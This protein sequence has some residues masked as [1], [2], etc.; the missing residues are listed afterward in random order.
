MPHDA[1]AATATVTV[2]G[3]AAR[4]VEPDEA[5]LAVTLEALSSDPGSALADV[6]RRSEALGALLDELAIAAADR[7]TTRVSVQEEVDHVHGER[8]SRGHRAVATVSVRVTDSKPLGALLTRTTS[9]LGARVDGPHWR[10]AEDNPAH[11]QAARDAAAASRRRAQAYAEGVGA[12]LGRVIALSEP[13][14]SVVRPTRLSNAAI[15]MA[16]PAG[17]PMPVE[18]GEQQVVAVVEATFALEPQS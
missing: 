4:R 11:L 2:M 6:S 9:E 13:A 12:R 3:T 8:R 5:T 10:I 1:Q 7:S 15:A 14:T 16:A 17:P 18:A